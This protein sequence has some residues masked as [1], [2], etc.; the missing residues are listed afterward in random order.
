MATFLRFFLMKDKLS[1]SKGFTL[2]EVVVAITVIAIGMFAIMSLLL[3]VI[4]GNSHSERVTTATNIAQDKM[5][6]LKRVGY[7]NVSNDSG[8]DQDYYWEA[9]IQDNTPG[10]NTITITVDVYWTP[11][12]TTSMHKVQLQTIIIQ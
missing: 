12:T 4:K 7:S 3:T 9:N 5:E 6:D 10:T 11:A 1:N 8:N 2:I